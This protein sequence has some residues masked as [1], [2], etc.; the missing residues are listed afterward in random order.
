GGAPLLGNT[1]TFSG[2]SAPSSSG[3]AID[4]AGSAT[5]T[6]S[7]LANST[8]GGNCAGTGTPPVTNGG[9]NISDDGT[10]GFGNSMA[11]NGDTIGDNVNDTNLALDPNGLQNNGGPTHTIALE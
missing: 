9:S 3:G 7:I 5:V 1:S 4:N 10:C 2:N 11:A 6:N 8:S